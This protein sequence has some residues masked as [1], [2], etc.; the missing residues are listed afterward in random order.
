MTDPC[1]TRLRLEADATGAIWL[2]GEQFR[3]RITLEDAGLLARA[4]CRARRYAA[5]DLQNGA[6]LE[7]CT[8]ARR[9]A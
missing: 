4:I 6:S 3:H 8:E 1:A 9:A 7:K 5:I 2:L